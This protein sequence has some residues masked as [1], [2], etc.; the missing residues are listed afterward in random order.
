MSPP[1]EERARIPSLALLRRPGFA[2][3]RETKRNGNQPTATC[4]GG[5]RFSASAAWL[6]I[7]WQLTSRRKRE[8]RAA[9]LIDMRIRRPW[10]AKAF[11]TGPTLAERASQGLVC[12]LFGDDGWPL[13]SG[14]LF[15]RRKSRALLLVARCVPAS[16]SDGRVA[17][18]VRI[19]DAHLRR[20]RV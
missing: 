15:R 16:Q 7:S 4:C 18:L 19:G 10:R 3:G 20:P 6:P 8:R 9:G 2:S 12:N 5:R 11:R 1:G 13:T 17:S 14:A